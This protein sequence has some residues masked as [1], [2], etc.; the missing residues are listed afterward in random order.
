MASSTVASADRSRRHDLDALRAFAM[1]LGIALHASLSFL[2]GVWPVQDRQQSPL[3]GVFLD[4]VHGFRMPLFFLLSGFFT[5]MIFRKRGMGELVK[6]RL[7]RIGLP[8]LLGLGTI[9]PAMDL[10]MAW[11]TS[12]GRG[13]TAEFKEPLIKAVR[14]GDLAAVKDSLKQGADIEAPDSSR[15][16]TPLHWACLL[17]DEAIVDALL[18]HGAKAGQPNPD[19]NTPLHAAVFLGHDRIVGRLLEKGADPNH[20][21]N[22]G[23]PPLSSAFVPWGVTQWIL[24]V[25]ALPEPKQEV[26]EAGRERVRQLLTGLTTV[27]LEPSAQPA[28]SSPRELVRSYWAFLGS[29][30]FRLPIGSEGFQLFN[31]G[32]FHHLWFLWHLCWMLLLFCAAVGIC[33]VACGQNWKLSPRM[34]SIACWLLPWGTLAM[35]PFMGGMGEHFGPDTSTAILPPP[36]LLAYYA[37]FFF[38]GV[39]YHVVG[40]EEA[41]LGRHWIAL[42]LAGLLVLLPVGLATKASPGW[43]ALVQTAYVWSMTFALMGMFHTLLNRPIAGVRYISD[44]AYWMYLIHQ[45]LV[46]LV[47]G[48]VRNWLVAALPKFLFVNLLVFALLLVTYEYW[49]RYTWV[50]T[51]LNGRRERPQRLVTSPSA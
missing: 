10:L 20:R 15:K 46:V 36:H 7:F 19:G 43:A 34:A 37:C 16:I 6:Q 31:T 41:K 5:M 21:N 28:D 50:G 48:L 26:V 33:R 40:D 47:Q 2:P 3:F 4:A 25:L 8:L 22:D 42:L 1:L 13:S 35:Q 44:A 17:G 39:C 45:P 18:E 29:D 27:A 9:I 38:F 14:A 12:L 49:V 11:G 23:R 24:G 51:M 30:R 32:V